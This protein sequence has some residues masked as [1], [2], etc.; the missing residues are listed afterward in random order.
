MIGNVNGA[1]SMIEKEM[2]NAGIDRKLVKTHSIIRLEALCAKSL[3]MQ[4]V[5]QVVIKIV[6][7]VRARGLHHRQFQHMLEEMDNQ[8]GDL[9][10]YYEVHWLSRS[11]MLQRVYQLRAELTNLLREKGWN[12]QSSVMRNG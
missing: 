6:N 12:F 2:R 9:L 4:E 3:K 7:F 11:A 8:Y 5:M 1:V 10:Y